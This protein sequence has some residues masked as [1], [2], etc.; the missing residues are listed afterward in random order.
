M[1]QTIQ[2][3]LVCES[4]RTRLEMR[5][6]DL[7]KSSVGAYLWEPMGSPIISGSPALFYQAMIKVR[8][9]I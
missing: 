5:I 3:L 8:M 4:D 9:K 6:N 1:K 2:Y 7:L